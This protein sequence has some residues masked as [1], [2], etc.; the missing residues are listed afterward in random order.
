MSPEKEAIYRAYYAEWEAAF[1]V[2]L[3]N[4]IQSDPRTDELFKN[5]IRYARLAPDHALECLKDIA[6]SDL[7]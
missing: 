6:K 4:L 3:G 1:R 7:L 5:H 2:M